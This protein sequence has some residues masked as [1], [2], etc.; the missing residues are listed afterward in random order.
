MITYSLHAKHC[1]WNV[2]GVFFT[3]VAGSLSIEMSVSTTYLPISVQVH[4]III[5]LWFG[6]I[7]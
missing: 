5:I 6:S 2:C 4:V 7:I 1:Y 3:T